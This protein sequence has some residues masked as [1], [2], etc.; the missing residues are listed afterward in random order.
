MGAK[1]AGVHLRCDDSNAVL[2]KLKREFGEKKTG[3]S[4]KDVAAM[5][6]IKAIARKNIAEIADPTEKAEKNA[7][8][9]Q[10]M[11]NAQR[12]MMAGD[13]AVIVVREHFVSIY[14][15]DHIRSENLSQEMLEY[16]AVCGV[17]AMGVSVYDDANFTLCAVCNAGMPDAHGCRG[18]YLFDYDDITPVEAEA[19]CDTINAPFLLEALKKTLSC[20][21]G[22]RM[23]AVFEEETGILIFMDETECKKSGMKELYKWGNAAVFGTTG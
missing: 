20:G 1:H 3:P 23:A 6:I 11:R 10:I 5:E 4:K 12:D 14:W 16:A 8:I 17:P 9:E 21:D 22:E 19:V 7:F 13:P 15:Y 2:P 18:E